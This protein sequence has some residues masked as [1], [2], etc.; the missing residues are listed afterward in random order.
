M[1][2]AFSLAM[3]GGIGGGGITV[4]VNLIFLNFPFSN[5]VALSKISIFAGAF[6][7]YMIEI[8]QKCPL[9]GKEH[10]PLID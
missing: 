8:C 1:F 5:A 10:F 6:I 3:A 7:R 4:P 9:K 2:I